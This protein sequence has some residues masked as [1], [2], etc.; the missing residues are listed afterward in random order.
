[1]VAERTSYLE[2]QLEASDWNTEAMHENH[3]ILNE[4]L[5]ELEGTLRSD[6]ARE[7][8]RYQAKLQRVA[9]TLR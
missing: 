7:A 1:M 8:S 2:L 6:N 3:V 4:Q 5:D 9:R